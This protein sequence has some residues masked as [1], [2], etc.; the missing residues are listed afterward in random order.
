MDKYKVI[1]KLRRSG[2]SLAINIPIEIV[3]LLDLKEND[4]IE[5]ELKKIK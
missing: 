5:I 1:K 2:T 4:L 3:E